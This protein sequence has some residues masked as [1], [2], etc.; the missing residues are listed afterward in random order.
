MKLRK[1]IKTIL[2][3]L[4]ST[5]RGLRWM[6]VAF[7]IVTLAV[8]IILVVMP[9]GYEKKSDKALRVKV[10]V[11]STRDD[12]VHNYGVVKQGEQ[13]ARVRVLGGK[14]LDQE[15]EAVNL[16]YG[17]P[18][19]DK[20]YRPGD[21]ALAVIDVSEDG[22]NP[23]AVTLTDYYRLDWEF[24][25]IAVFFLL[26]LLFSGWTGLK[27][28]V[29]FA[30]SAIATWKLLIPALLAGSSP[31]VASLGTVTILTAVIV[32]LVA[33]FT[34]T[35]L[36]AF[37]GSL[38]GTAASA[39]LAL[40]VSGPYHLNGSV[41]PFSETLRFGGFEHLDITQL[42]LAG[43]ILASS[44][45]LM[46]LAIDISAA[47]EEVHIKRPDLSFKA[48]ALSG[49]SVSRKVTST[50]FTTLILAYTGSYTSLLMVFMAQGVPMA[51]F[52]N[53][54]Y[55][56]SEIFQTM[57]GTFGLLSIAPFTALIGAALFAREKVPAEKSKLVQETEDRAERNVPA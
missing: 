9:T 39:I 33:G 25:L 5:W 28:G 29:S 52:F 31:I 19:L 32:F 47:L 45:A 38:L 54:S 2:D 24:G 12:E 48:L 51:N 20:M 21:R 11:L 57:I 7:T 26:L 36:A 10:L 40:L 37:L 30:F 27:S 35:G 15:F 44:G 22:K 46:D 43:T 8:T 56:S 23:A 41:R 4:L 16:L 3:Y 42:F 17:K 34:K 13:T 14:Y 49:L 18:E 55:V 50:M 53:V 6:D 1:T